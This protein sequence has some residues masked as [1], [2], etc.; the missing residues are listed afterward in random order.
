MKN[1]NNSFINSYH[2]KNHK[3]NIAI[4]LSSSNSTQY[5]INKPAYYG[6]DKDWMLIWPGYFL[7]LFGT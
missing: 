4:S 1:N 5:N 2:N 6:F 7:S 3:T